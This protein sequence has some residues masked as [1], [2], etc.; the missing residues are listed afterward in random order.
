[1][2]EHS[3]LRL[4]Y[5]LTVEPSYNLALQQ[6]NRVDDKIQSILA[7][8]GVLTFTMLLAVGAL[9]LS[10]SPWWSFSILGIALLEGVVLL[11]GRFVVAGGDVQCL[12]PGKVYNSLKQGDLDEETAMRS[13]IVAAQ[14][15]FDYNTKKIITPRWRCA[16]VL[17]LLM[18]GKLLMFSVWVLSDFLSSR[19][20][21][22]LSLVDCLH[23][24]LS[25][26][27]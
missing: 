15:S 2:S 12:T 14:E 4:I 17:A 20:Q 22:P 6:A 9:G 10:G 13:L 16:L 11:V 23:P 25:V 21:S 1:M 18:V 27:L 19:C 3:S 26:Y 24:L 5:R 7:T 8:S